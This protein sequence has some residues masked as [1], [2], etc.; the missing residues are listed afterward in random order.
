MP[1]ISFESSKI[2]VNAPVE[3]NIP[4][5]TILLD[6]IR[7]AGIL[8][9]APCGGKGACGKCLVRIVEGDV[10]SD[11]LGALPRS[12][13]AEGFVLACKTQV[14]DTP[15]RV[16]VP[17]Q[18]SRKG[19]KFT[20]ASEDMKL[21][22]HELFPKNWQYDPL[23]VK[24]YVDVPPPQL[25]DGNSDIDR[26]TLRLQQDWGKRE[27]IY[28]LPL[29]RKVAEA[30]RAKSGKITA[31]LIRDQARYHV[32]NIEPGDHTTRHYGIAVDIGTTTVAVQ[33]VFLPLAEVVTTCIDYN[34]Q[35]S[36]GLDVISRI[37]YAGK[38]EK[39]EE[40]REKVLGTINRLIRH[41]SVP[42][43][44][45]PEEISNAVI[46]GN[47]TMIHLLLGL[48]PEYIRLEPYTPTLLETPYLTAA[49]VGIE[50][51]PQSWIYISP[52]VGS[53]VGGDISSGILCTDLAA[54]TE[55][56][57]LFIDIGTNGEIVVGNCDFLMTCACSA[58]PA[59]EGGGIK[60]GMR[61]ALGA[62][63]SVEIDTESGKATYRTIGNV[64]PRGIC[65][66]GMIAL[67]AELFLKG[68]IDG[69]GKL[70]RK[71]SSDS[72]RIEGRNSQYIIV[73]DNMSESGSEIVIT[74]L[75]IANIIRAKAA[76][77]SATSLM[78]NQL[79][80]D[81]DNIDKIYIAGGFG[82]FLDLERAKIIGL[83]PDMPREKFNFIGNASLMGARMIL[84][85]QE[86]RQKQSDLAKRMTYLEL[87]TDPDYMD[88][89][90]GALF[91]PHTDMNRFPYVK[92]LLEIQ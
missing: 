42:N 83:L 55:E 19:A 38:P 51:N 45:K 71:K 65:G 18:E 30:L 25:E 68:W 1:L 7:K 12:V 64:K 49:D 48:P 29:I 32:I 21:V 33:L 82:R 10:K 50:I 72:I 87:N 14:L 78:L 46:S 81:F 23:A 54:G 69:A 35:I 73:P 4:P 61:A 20:D 2:T 27:M 79:D 76:I 77:Y 31:T 70:N 88:Q 13:L 40:L 36:C 92:K 86:F 43:D 85:S 15:V 52:S 75:D 80:L 59:F 47:T 6:A 58:G 91:L 24:W 9:D 39:L 26:L 8:I 5:G 53:Y 11:S 22:R 17:D 90:T 63:E 37:N 62:I 84:V 89:Y 41:A 56:I 16:E 66:S 67:I 34:D 3:I 44:V 28:S 74:E 57:S 60:N